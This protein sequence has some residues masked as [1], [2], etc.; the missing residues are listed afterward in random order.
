MQ[1][2]DGRAGSGEGDVQF[3]AVG[4]DAA[5]FGHG[6]SSVVVRNGDQLTLGNYAGRSKTALPPQ[7]VSSE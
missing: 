2:Q 1:Q 5:Q 6:D 7:V 4:E 3:D